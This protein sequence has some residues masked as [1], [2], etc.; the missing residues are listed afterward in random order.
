MT[1]EVVS[2]PTARSHSQLMLDYLERA[3]QLQPFYKY[4]FSID[5]FSS[6]IQDKQFD[7]DNR[8]ILSQALSEQYQGIATSQRVLDNIASLQQEKTFTITTAHQPN[9]FTGRLYFIYKIIDAINATEQLN[10]AFPDHHFVPMYYMG[11]EDHD[12]EEINHIYLFGEKLEWESASS[13]GAVGRMSTSGM[14]PLITRIGEKL[15]GRPKTDSLLQILRDAY[16]GQ[17]TLAEATL[18][19][20]DQLFSEFGLVVLIP[21]NRQL[22]QLFTPVIKQEITK[23]VGIALSEP[24]MS[25]MEKL[26][27]KSQ[28][29]PR[30]VNFFFHADN[31][32]ERIVHNDDTK[33]YEVL[34]TKLVF[35]EQE[36][37][38]RI[39][40]QPECFSPNVFFRPLYQET[41]LPNLAYIGGGGELAYWL[42]QK[43]I[44]DHF[45]VNFPMLMLRNSV[46]LVD[47]NTNKKIE[48]TGLSV[49]DLFVDEEDLVKDYVKKNT[50]RSLDL[51]EEKA[52]IE[53]VFKQVL[54]KASSVD[55][56]LNKA[57]EGQKTGMIKALENIESKILRAEKK[58]YEVS[59]NQIRSVK[60][61]LFPNGNLQERYDNFLPFYADKGQNFINELK[62]Q[63]DPFD[64]NFTVLF[65]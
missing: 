6:I 44:F 38:A 60:H 51:N 50:V 48:K 47:A 10:Q 45:D 5:A 27:Y 31:K 20:V 14:E 56:S 28:A 59:V 13:G 62:Q 63:L 53:E 22:K 41:I 12:F 19:L 18:Y 43:P 61:R 39:E 8:K 64:K 46:L 25:Q 11:G 65:D 42:Q 52:A 15:S 1:K 57:V 37:V 7:V 3:D 24:V 2:Y 33:Q 30:E 23:K 9:V 55:Q 35:T 54:D 49:Q 40:D 17:K 34:N 21:D 16:L 4:P 58:N 32:R 36:L 29:N 26:G